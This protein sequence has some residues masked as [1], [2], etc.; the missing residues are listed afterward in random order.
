MAEKLRAHRWKIV[1]NVITFAALGGAIYA[2][3]H[4]IIDTLQNLEDLNP[5]ILLFMV[6][7]QFM[8]Y[9]FVALLYKSLFGLLGSLVSYRFLFKAA[10]ELNFVNLVF[11]SGG[12]SGFSYF[13]IRMRSAQISAGKATLVQTMRFVLLFVAF[14][15]LL[16]VGLI[17]LA[18]DGKANNFMILISGSLGTLLAVG[19]LGLS[20]IIGSEKR[21][22]AFF[23]FVTKVL[24]RII[25]VVRRKHP[26]TI[27]V[28]KAKSVFKD[29]HGNYN[30]IKSS[31]SKLRKPLL[32]A[33]LINTFEIMTIYAVFAAFGQWINPGAI[34]IAYAVA[35]FAGLISVLP[36][37]IGIYEALMTGVL[38]AGGIPPALSLPIIVTYRIINMGIQL[39][40]GGFLYNRALRE[41]SGEKVQDG[42]LV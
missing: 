24:N 21:I 11:P 36:G 5:F 16:F 29:F 17:M 30:I 22:D 9:H 4:Q 8:H 23:T 34:I 38:A 12:V 18:L 33:L 39:P 13:S 2:L 3:R 1:I 37:G 42:R 19:T 10:L 14:Q 41:V 15:I 7:F 40:A 35:N 6:A 28:S 32:Y 20:Y 27:N 25:Q 31:Y 26:E